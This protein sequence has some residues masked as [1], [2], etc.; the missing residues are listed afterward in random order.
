MWLGWE[1]AEEK[2]KLRKSEGG[3]EAFYVVVCSNENDTR[4]EIRVF[5]KGRKF[6]T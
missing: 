1:E 6:V 3:E 4:L 2:E 5:R